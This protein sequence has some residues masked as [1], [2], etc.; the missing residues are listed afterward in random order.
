VHLL[1]CKI[2]NGLGLSGLLLCPVAGFREQGSSHP[3]S[4]KSG[5]YLNSQIYYLFLKKKER[6][7]MYSNLPRD[8]QV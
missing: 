5:G 8:L 2:N 1:V 3:G 6:R 7:V 4:I